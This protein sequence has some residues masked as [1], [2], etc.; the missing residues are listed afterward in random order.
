MNII[1]FNFYK[2]IIIS[3]KLNINWNYYFILNYNKIIY[4]FL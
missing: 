1:K 4:L 3:E 2:F